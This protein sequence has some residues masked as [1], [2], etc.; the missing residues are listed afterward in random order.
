VS[1]EIRRQI[2][3]RVEQRLQKLLCVRTVHSGFSS[4]RNAPNS[5][6]NPRLT[7]TLTTDSHGFARTG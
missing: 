3:E 2:I 7:S 6:K 4:T 5:M 1:S